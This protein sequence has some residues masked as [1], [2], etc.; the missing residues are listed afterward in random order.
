L[1]HSD[2]GILRTE[3]GV[4]RK[5]V[6]MMAGEVRAG[7]IERGKHCKDMRDLTHWQALE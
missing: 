2:E 7:K 5:Q 3:R 4:D 1:Q 6:S